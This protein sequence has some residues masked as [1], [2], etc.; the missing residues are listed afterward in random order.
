MIAVGVD[1]H[2]DCHVAAALDRLG[3]LRG[4]L[5]IDADRRGYAELAAWAHRLGDEV[6]VGIEGAGSWGA[7]LCEYLQVEGVVVFEVERP[8][9]SER[10]A[11]KSDRL[12]ALTAAKRVLAA[13]GL[14]TPRARGVRDAV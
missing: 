7:G 3:E 6:L 1:T 8:R 4:E 14:S 2:K 12:D 10:R 11:G 9:R 5:T 13:E